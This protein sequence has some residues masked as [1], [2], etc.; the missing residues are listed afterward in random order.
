MGLGN[1]R[2][3][4]RS[5]VDAVMAKLTDEQ[6]E[7]LWR[8]TI[9]TA[10]NIFSP[11]TSLEYGRA[12]YEAVR[13]M[14]LAEALAEPSEEEWFVVVG[15]DYSAIPAPEA[16]RKVRRLVYNRLRALTAPPVDPAVEAV[17]KELM[18]MGDSDEQYRSCAEKVVAAVRAI[19]KV[20]S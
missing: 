18:V 15:H 19:D 10:G 16:L 20:R 4:L 8:T 14:V 2:R 13:P 3:D 7:E 17:L 5:Q 12:A 6:Y 11:R 1:L 9:K